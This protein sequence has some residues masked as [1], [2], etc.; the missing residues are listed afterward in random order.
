VEGGI[1]NVC[2]L[3]PESALGEHGFDPGRFIDSWPALRERLSP[4]SRAMGWL[5]TG[6]LAFGFDRSP[7]ACNHYRAGDALGFIDP[8]TGSGIL[9]AILT[10]RLAGVAAA[11]GIPSNEY[12]R[13]CARLL[14]IQYRVSSLL[15]FAVLSGW[16]EELARWA[17]GNLLFYLTRPHLA[18]K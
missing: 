15:R 5:T 12:Q 4:L 3:A 17:P 2:G 16:A 1:T 8:F 18:L 7:S 6:P 13:Q 10:G 9:S 11:R 14:R